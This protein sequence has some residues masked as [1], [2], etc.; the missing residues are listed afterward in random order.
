MMIVGYLSGGCREVKVAFHTRIP[1]G[2][3]GRG[4]L[5][6]MS[7]G[8]KLTCHNCADRGGREKKEIKKRGRLLL[9]FKHLPSRISLHHLCHHSLPG[10]SSPRHSPHSEGNKTAY[11]DDKGDRSYKTPYEMIVHT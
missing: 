10:P 7:S 8:S 5:G 1:R 4:K 11:H 6:N 3:G 9:R 2:G